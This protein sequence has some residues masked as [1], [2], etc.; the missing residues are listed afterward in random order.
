MRFK[1]KVAIVAG[2][3]QGIG[4]GIAAALAAEGAEVIV[5]DI[6]EQ[7]VQEAVKKIK[8]DNGKAK[9][10]IM[11][12]LNYDQVKAGVE[13]VVNEFGKLDIICSTVGGGKNKPF[14]DYT[15][16]FFKQQVGFNL[17]SVFNCAHA[18]LAPMMEKNYGKML[19]FTSSTGGQADLCG[20]QAG[21]AG[22]ESLVKT[23][24]TELGKSKAKININ[25]IHPGICD[26]PLTRDFFYAMPNG[27]QIYQ[28]M[29]SR[30]PHGMNTPADIAKLALFLVSD[31]AKRLTGVTLSSTL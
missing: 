5:W 15:P 24:V 18:A 17:D 9:A 4:E 2:G 3:S 23:L 29:A 25:L 26:T 27:E 28:S 6:N 22:M 19:F 12:V 13:Q 14:K 11:D 30:T 8:A 31:E 21:K 10:V 1:D 7:G 16:D 20:Y